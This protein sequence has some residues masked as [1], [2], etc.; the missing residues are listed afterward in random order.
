MQFS[1]GIQ[2]IIYGYNLLENAVLKK[3]IVMKFTTSTNF[4][5]FFELPLIYADVV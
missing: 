1:W 4:Y 5:P 3:E 2:S